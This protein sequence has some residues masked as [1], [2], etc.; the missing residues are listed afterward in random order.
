MKKLS[1]LIFAACLLVPAL[2][3]AQVNPALY[4]EVYDFGM[5]EPDPVPDKVCYCEGPPT[6]PIHCYDAKTPGMSY[7][8]VPLHVGK[9]PDG[10][11]GVPYGQTTSGAAVI[12][13][14]A[15]A[16][17]QFLKSPSTAGEPAAIGFSSTG[18]CHL[19]HRHPGYT[20]YLTT[21]VDPTYFQIVNNADLAHNY[22]LD[23]DYNYQTGTTVGGQAQ[24]GGTQDIVCEGDP[25]NVELTTW[26]KIK[27]LYR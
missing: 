10:F 18:P 4:L 16:C 23:C 24:W 12:F 26:G 11:R 8:Y 19:W 13:L 15:V 5:T 6:L 20:K 3:F 27:G 17:N 22:V 14:S 9:V 21:N 1:A 2:G 25:T 7:G